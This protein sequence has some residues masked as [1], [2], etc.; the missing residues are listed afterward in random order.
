MAGSGEA[1]GAVPPEA[2][3]KGALEGLTGEPLA[4]A[5]A[6]QSQTAVDIA[7]MYLATTAPSSRG[8]GDA[9]NL[10]VRG[11]RA[12]EEELHAVRVRGAVRREEQP[13]AV[14]LYAKEHQPISVHMRK[15]AA[16]VQQNLPEA[17]ARIR[18]ALA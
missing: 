17:L 13:R 11:G 18:E 12:E 5:H 4:H 8:D 6:H 16:L 2:G 15:G 14:F 1:A 9:V 3:G 7:A 10:D